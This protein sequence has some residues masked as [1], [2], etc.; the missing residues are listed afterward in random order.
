MAAVCT[1]LGK[2]LDVM[3]L[4]LEGPRVGEVEVEAS[5]L[6]ASVDP[7]L[8]SSRASCRDRCRSCSAMKGRASSVQ[9]ARE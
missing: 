2:P 1:S 9:W 3:E 7:T 4:L 8:R 5:V 6:R